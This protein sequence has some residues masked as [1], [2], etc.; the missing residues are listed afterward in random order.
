MIRLRDTIPKTYRFV[1][2]DN[3]LSS[4]GSIS[5]A[6][7]VD[8]WKKPSRTYYS[9]RRWR[10][11]SSSTENGPS[12]LFHPGSAPLVD[13]TLGQLLDQAA[14]RFPKRNCIVSVHQN[15]R[16]TFSEARK[17]AD[18]LAAGLKKLGL[19]KGDR[20][21]LWGP[22]TIEWYI[23]FLASTRA[24]FKIVGINPADQ[25]TEL[26]YGLKKVGVRA[27]VAPDIFKTQNYPEMLL[28]AKSRCP[29]LEHIIIAS[30]KHFTGTCRFV[31]V[32]SL[33]SSIE[34]ETIGAEQSE[35]SPNSGATIQFTSGTTGRPKAA[36]VSHTSYTNNARQG[37]Q[38]LELGNA[39]NTICLNVPLFHAFALVMGLAGHLHAGSTLV[40]AGP[41][42]NPSEAIN[43]IVKEKCTAIYG[44]P[45]MWVD[46]VNRQQE[47][48]APIGK[49][50][51]GLTGGSPASPDL[52]QRTRETFGFDN[53]KSIYGLTETTAICFQSLPDTSKEL[54]ETTVG[55][56]SD[57]TEA[58]VV[59]KNG[60]PVPFG[61]PGELWVR[62][63]HTMIGYWEDEENTRKTVD[64]NGWLKTGDQF[65]IRPD[66]HGRV[67]G[68]L[69]DM[70]IR[71]GE[72]IFPK[73]IEDFLETHPGVIEAHV[74]GVHDDRLGEDV[75][76]CIRLRKGFELTVDDVR[77]YGKG[78]IAHFKIPRYVHLVQEFPKT[79]TGKVKKN[80]LR[81]ALEARGTV[82]TRPKFN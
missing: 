4:L 14:N 17:R 2:L 11:T 7:F 69:K 50:S 49:I 3:S 81:E 33:P 31:D 45:T 63:Y 79:T 76:A 47:M 55:H 26:E 9:S 29:T 6:S 65:I 75:C 70:L 24:G 8:L 64:E 60:V 61:T 5:T 58:Q 21:G 23:T 43:A 19:N 51:Q 10:S 52:F 68:R 32:E 18:T 78:K 77:E 34:V 39:H 30:D 46:M 1:G 59:D 22:N 67:I 42:F 72:N 74:F 56:L 40:L 73:E 27:V 28:D 41:S 15:I 57:H 54:A 16:L 12:Y 20:I 80:L 37:M 35:I 82:P 44:T 62:G 25:P 13:Q 53:M 48:N 66:G 38:R 71:G 36:E